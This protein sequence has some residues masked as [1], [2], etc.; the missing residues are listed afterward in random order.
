MPRSPRSPHGTNL[1]IEVCPLAKCR[2]AEG[3]LHVSQSSLR[4]AESPLHVQRMRPYRAEGSLRFPW[5]GQV[6]PKWLKSKM[7]KKCRQSYT[8]T[9]RGR[10]SSIEAKVR[11]QFTYSFRIDELG[12]R[13]GGEGAQGGG[14]QVGGKLPL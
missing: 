1:C 8:D 12:P 6:G 10:I 14:G 3:S 11:P 7:D 2:R 9:P 5:T 4:R 13:S